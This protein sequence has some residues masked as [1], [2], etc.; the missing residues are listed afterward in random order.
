MPKVTASSFADPADVKAY[1]DAI[2]AGKSE[3]EALKVGDN[4]IGAW[5]DDTTSESTPMCA[6]PPEDWK[7][8]WKTGKAARGKRV[9]VTYKGQ[10]EIGELRDTMP[11]KANI[12]NGAGIDLNPGF[13]K[14]F[15][16]RQPFMLK[17]VQWDWADDVVA[18][19]AQPLVAEAAA[20]A[21][22]DY[23]EQIAKPA[24]QGINQGLTSPSSSFMI[25]LLGLPRPDLT[26]KCQ[27]P[28]DAA[29][30]KRVETRAVGPIRVTGLSVALDALERIF[31]DVKS[32]LPDLYALIGTEGMMCCRYKKIRGKIVKDPSNHT[33][34]TA[35]DLTLGKVLDTQGDDKVQRGLLIL[36]RY[37]NAHGWYWGAA[38]PTEDGMH[39]E[40]SREQFIK[41]QDAGLL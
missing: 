20:P 41:W 13:A 12:K 23:L 24:R 16:V 3:Q 1:R 9:A 5:G 27:P 14:R 26:G 6:L 34:G 33:W 22:V 11:A 2:A 35:V 29:F 32:E 31:A 18:A 17:N 37:F 25:S 19:A 7:G 15:G 36:S 10:T 30:K 8:R 40:V 4:G 39:F 21:T 28:T 38:F